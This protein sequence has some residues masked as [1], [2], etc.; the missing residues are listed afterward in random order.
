MIP[1]VSAIVI[2][3]PM[4]DEREIAQACGSGVAVVGHPGPQEDVLGRFAAVVKSRPSYPTVMRITGDCPLLSPEIAEAVAVLYEESPAAV[5]AWNVTPGY[6]DGEDV[7]VMDR[8]A[9]LWADRRATDPEDREHVTPIIRRHL[10]M[11]TL[12]APDLRGWIEKTSV[13]TPEDFAR[14]ERD[15]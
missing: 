4:G 6:V 10:P 14:L 15:E 13:D 11:V 2:A 5:Y 1:S 12:P 3:V 8:D 7:E 9:L